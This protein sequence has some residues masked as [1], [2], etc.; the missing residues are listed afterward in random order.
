VPGSSPLGAEEDGEVVGAPGWWGA[1]REEK[2][3][4]NDADGFYA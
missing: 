2:G 1:H 4:R 3:V